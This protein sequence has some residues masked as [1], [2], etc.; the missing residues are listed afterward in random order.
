[1]PIYEYVCE[2]GCET[3]EIQAIGAEA[4]ACLSCGGAMRKKFS[5]IALFR[6]KWDGLTARSKGYKEG[7]KKEYLKSKNQEAWRG[8]I[9]EEPQ[10]QG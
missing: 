10:A 5:P 3:T 8:T 6:I 9:V 2:C 1:M 7:Y 4:P